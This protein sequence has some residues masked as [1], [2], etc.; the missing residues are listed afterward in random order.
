MLAQVR[1]RWPVHVLQGFQEAGEHGE[2]CAQFVRN[3]GHET[4][5]HVFELREMRHVARDHQLLVAAERDDA[6][7]QRALWLRWGGHFQRFTVVA[8]VQV[9]V[10]FRVTHQVDEALPGVARRGDAEQTFARRI[11]PLNLVVARHDQHGVRCG[12]RGAL[13]TRQHFG[14]PVFA[15]LGFFCHGAK[16]VEHFAPQ[17]AGVRHVL[18]LAHQPA[19]ELHEIAQVE[20]DVHAETECGNQKRVT[21]DLGKQQARERDADKDPDFAPQ[22]FGHVSVLC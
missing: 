6:H 18:A 16:T 10:E 1:A 14:E 13:E 3:V 17:A 9:G 7:R 19:V 4:A 12:G 20:G 8:L 22:I 11:R 21:G 2:R 5:A 15:L